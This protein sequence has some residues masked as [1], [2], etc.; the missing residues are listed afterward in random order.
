MKNRAKAKKATKSKP[1][2]GMDDVIKELQTKLKAEQQLAPQ[3]NEVSQS[4]EQ[5]A[6]LLGEAEE[7]KHEAETLTKATMSSNR[8]KQFFN[9]RKLQKELA[10]TEAELKDI[11]TRLAACRDEKWQL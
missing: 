6:S 3:I 8:F 7:L 11:A 1:Q 4:I 10:D 2:I 5:T 9:F